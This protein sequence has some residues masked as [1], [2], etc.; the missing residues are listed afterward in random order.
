MKRHIYKFG[1]L[2]FAFFVVAA[3][4]EFDDD[5]EKRNTDIKN[6]EV[7][8][9]GPLFA[10]AILDYFYLMLETSVNN[11]VFRL[12]AQ[13][14][15]QTTYPDE[16]QYN[17]TTRNIGRNMWRTLYRDVL[18]D[19]DGAK[20]S[21]ANEVLPGVDPEGEEAVRDNQLA[22]I[23]IIEVLAYSNL[24]DLFGN[25]PYTEAIDIENPDPTYDDAATVYNN[26]LDELNE[27]ID[28]INLDYSGLTLNDPIYN[29]NMSKWLAYANSLKLRLAMRLVDVNPT[30][31]QTLAEEAASQ[32]LIMNNANNFKIEYLALSPNTNPLWVDL[33]QSGRHDFVSSNHMV[34]YLNNIQDPR[35]H[36]FYDLASFRFSKNDNNT[37][38]D[39]E[40][41]GTGTAFVFYDG[42]E[43]VVT[44]PYTVSAVD[45]SST[46]EYYVGGTYGTA[47]SYSK[48]SHIGELFHDPLLNGVLMS[49]AEVRFLLAEAA[50]RGFTV[51][52]TAEEHYNAAILASMEEWG[53]TTEKAQAYLEQPSIAYATA[54]GT[55]KEKIGAQKWIS[56]FNNGFEGWTSYRLL[57][58][59][60]LQGF[61]IYD[62][63]NNL[64]GYEAPSVP[65][66]FLYPVEEATLNGDM[67]DAAAAAIGGDEMETKLFWDVN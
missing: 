11:N 51:T 19:L 56:L 12:Y 26:I 16:S 32:S 59:G 17:Q 7:V 46:I 14:W 43:R 4:S 48:S 53:I 67:Y 44:L 33:V 30:L 47:N 29:A 8:P 13:Y 2:L 58:F 62:D 50:E 65:T 37:T 24:V 55:W 63:D 6:P 40:I 15:A 42:E 39:T 23:Q 10:N 27:A 28:M 36:V 20:T 31:A 35:I 64:I 61:P 60:I 22:T 54:T 21:I 57:D 3:C 49:A 34:N 38:I 41:G 5:L 18:K 45:S 9:A 1:L 52:G 25:V 66:R